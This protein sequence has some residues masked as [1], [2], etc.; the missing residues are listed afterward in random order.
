MHMFFSGSAQNTSLSFVYL[1]VVE[2]ESLPI[3][4]LQNTTVFRSEQGLSSATLMLT[5]SRVD[6]LFLLPLVFSCVILYFRRRV[7]CRAIKE[8]CPG[9]VAVAFQIVRAG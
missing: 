7:L 1:L 2:G 4:S 6:T 3:P 8:D 5:S 9:D